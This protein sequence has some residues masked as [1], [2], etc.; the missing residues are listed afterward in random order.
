LRTVERR[1]TGSAA[2]V[3]PAL[4]HKLHRRRDMTIEALWRGLLVAALATPAGL[5]CSGHGVAST[6][7]GCS[8]SGTSCAA[9]ACC[10]TPFD[11]CL[12]SGSDKI[13]ENAAPPRC[14]LSA[15]SNLPGVSIQFPEASCSFSLTQAAAGLQIAYQ[16]VVARPLNGVH[17]TP[18][19]D[20]RCQTPGASELIVG[21]DLSDDNQRYCLCDVG[22]CQAQPFTTALAAG[23]YAATIA[24]DGRNWSGPSDTGNPEGAAFPV[25]TFQLTLSASGTWADP[26]AGNPEPDAGA[27]GTSYAV[28]A[29]RQIVITN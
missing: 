1:A 6:D 20:G 2:F 29:V 7:A 3:A 19:D 15:S 10:Q 17:P 23:T 16:V 22:L 14:D 26:D 25:G 5:G 28:T 24:W 18:T 4:A 13:C 21:F 9:T 27:L 8:P 12:A 11:M